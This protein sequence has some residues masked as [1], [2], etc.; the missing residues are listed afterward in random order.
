MGEQAVLVTKAAGGFCVLDTQGSL[1]DSNYP[2]K[3]GTDT[4]DRLLVYA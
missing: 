2:R 4:C 3:G 1:K